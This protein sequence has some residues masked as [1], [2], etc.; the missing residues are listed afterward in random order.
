M[1]YLCAADRPASSKK[2]KRS[3]ITPP[4]G[5]H[6]LPR[7]GNNYCVLAGSVDDALEAYA[8]NET[9]DTLDAVIKTVLKKVTRSLSW[10]IAIQLLEDIRQEFEDAE[11]AVEDA[12]LEADANATKN[13]FKRIAAAVL[14]A[15]PAH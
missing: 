1:I 12:S 8:G 2:E 9:R 6:D 14:A 3:K 15:P 4:T 10:G 5:A 11:M 7:R 13:A